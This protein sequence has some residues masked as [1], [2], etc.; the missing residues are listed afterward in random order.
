MIRNYLYNPEKREQFN[1]Q[2]EI[3]QQSD[4]TNEENM[5]NDVKTWLNLKNQER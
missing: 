1:K 2:I 3:F 5:N 4:C